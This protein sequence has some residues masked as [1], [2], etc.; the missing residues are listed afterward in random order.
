MQRWIEVLECICE[1]CGYV[2]ICKVDVPKRCPNPGCK[3]P[4]WNKPRT[5][6]I[7][8]ARQARKRG[9]PALTDPQ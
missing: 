9:K 3:S 5:R 1:R 4:Y 6:N 2:W 8:L 7:P